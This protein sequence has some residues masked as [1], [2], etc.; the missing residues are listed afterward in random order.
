MVNAPVTSLMPSLRASSVENLALAPVSSTDTV[1][2]S[3]FAVSAGSTDFFRSSAATPVPLT[4]ATTCGRPLTSRTV[5]S[6]GLTSSTFFTAGSALLRSLPASRT[7]TRVEFSAVKVSDLAIMIGLIVKVPAR[8]ALTLIGADTAGSATFSRTWSASSSVTSG[9]TTSA[10]SSIGAVATRK[11]SSMAEAAACC[12]TVT[13]GCA[14]L[15]STFVPSYASA[16]FFGFWSTCLGQTRR[17]RTPAWPRRRQRS[18][19]W[20][21]RRSAPG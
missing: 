15:C 1:R 6:L 4:A 2:S 19:W 3:P 12:S 21:N 20:P 13:P 16:A 9:S 11:P 8:P 7:G 10:G 18:P 5:A 17:R 14:L